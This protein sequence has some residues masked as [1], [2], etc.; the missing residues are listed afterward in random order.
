M[1]ILRKLYAFFVDAVQSILIAASIFLV[2]YIFFFRPFQVNGESMFPNFEDKEYVLTNL[3][4]LR[5]DNPK[6]GD[7]VVFQAPVDA[8]KDFIKRVIGIPGDTVMIKDG[9]VYLNG[10]KLDESA[11]LKNDVKTYGGSFLK[12]NEPVT[13]PQ[14]QYF[15]MGDNRTYSSDSREWG[16]VKKSAVIG[17]S[18]F[19]YWPPNHMRTIKN[20]FAQSK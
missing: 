9:N 18:F 6:H 5:F 14:D 1:F 15:V 17:E 13:V 10:N 7:V 4:V 8:E 3:I 2:I 11:Y 16:F 12:E 20:P 19:V